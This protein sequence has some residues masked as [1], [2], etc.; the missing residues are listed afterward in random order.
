MSTKRQ[1][2]PLLNPI[3][4]IGVHQKVGQ[5][6]TD[7]I[8]LP[9]LCHLDAAHRGQADAAGAN[10]LTKHIVIALTLGSKA[11]NRAFYD[12]AGAAYDALR[13]ACM[14]P[15]EVL[16]FTTA[17]YQAM[18]RWIGAYLRVLP[19]CTVLALN[20]ACKNAERVL[21]DLDREAA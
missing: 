2:K 9:V 19:T 4:V 17:E 15:T 5:E 14:R 8:A 7:A 12:I 11:G 3:D 18:K 21:A 20:H 6:D 16:S 1:A 13:K 10:F